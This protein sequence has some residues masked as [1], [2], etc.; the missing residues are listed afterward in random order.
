MDAHAENDPEFAI[1]PPHCV[2]GTHGQHKAEA[3]L[4]EK[5]VVVPNRPVRLWRSTARSRLSWRSRTSTSSPRRNLARVV[6]RWRRT[7]SWSTAW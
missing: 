6:E 3:T 1:W 7:A 4:L 5:R 2:A